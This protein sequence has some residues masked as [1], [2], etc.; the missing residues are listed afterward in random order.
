MPS[1][2]LR[3]LALDGG[4]VR[5]LSA[6]LILEHLMETVD[7]DAPP[8]PC[9]YFDMIGGTST[10][11]LIAVMLGRLKMSVPDC[12]AAYISLSDRIFRK[13]RHRMTMR[14]RVQGRFNAEELTRA[15]KEVV[16]QQGLQEDAL[17][18]DAPE[19]Q[20]K[21]FV[22]ATSKQAGGT[23]CLTSYRTPRGNNDLLNSATIW[24][25]CRATSA[26]PSF[27]DSITIGR[28][29]EEFIDGATGAN[30]P[31]RE[32]WDQAQ[33]VWGPAPLEG[34]VKCLVS[35]GTGVPSLKPFKNDVLHMGKALLAIATDTEESAERFRR[36]RSLLDSTQRY[37]RFN[38]L[39]GL[40]EIGLQETKKIDE[41]AAATRRYI[42]S[43]EVRMQ[44]QA[45]AGNIAGREYFGEYQTV[46]RLD[47]VPRTRQ[48]IDRQAEMAEIER[49]LMPGH[50]ERQKIHVLRGLGGIGKTQLAVEFAYRHH[51]RF[52]SVFWL[53]GRTKDTLLRSIVSCASRIPAGHITETSRTYT[54]DSDADVRIIVN[55]VLA[56]LA[57]ANNT[58][59]LLIF[60]NVDREYGVKDGDPHAYDVEHYLPGAPHGSVLIT[61]RL[62]RLERLGDSQQLGKVSKMQAQAIFESWYRKEHDKVKSERLLKL[63]DGLPLAIA[64]A[65]AYLHET[66]AELTTY[67]SFYEQQW[68]ALMQSDKDYSDGSVWTTWSISYQAIRK[69]HKDTANLLLLWSFLDNKDLWYGLF[70]TACRESP[71]TASM[72]SSWIGD[73][74]SSEFRFTEAM[75]LLRNYSLVEQVAETLSYATHPVVHQ[76]AYHSQGQNFATELSRLAVVTIGSTVPEKNCREDIIL[77]RRLLSHAQACSSRIAK[78]GKGFD[79]SVF[80][81]DDKDLE[82]LEEQKT[83]FCAVHMLGSLYAEQG[84]P[85]EAEQMYKCAF[86]GYQ[87]LALGPFHEA[88]LS[89]VHK[90]GLLYVEQGKLDEAEQMYERALQGFEALGPDHTMMLGVVNNS[91]GLLYAEQ[92]KVEKAEQMYKRALRGYEALEPNHT[93][94]L[95]IVSNLGHLYLGQGKLE[96]AEQMYE[97]ALRGKEEALG[98]TDTFTLDTV[99]G[100]GNLYIEQG[101]LCK[102]EEMLKRALQGYEENVG[103]I[104]P[105]T[106]GVVNS[107]GNFYMVKEELGKAEQMY[108]RALRGYEEAVGPEQVQQYRPALNALENLGNL[109]VARKESTKARTAYVR[110]LSGLSHILDWKSAVYMELVAKIVAL[111]PV[112]EAGSE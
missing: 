74:A 100:L 2:D 42:S 17:L 87:S 112:S 40:E 66:G 12:I 56:W 6:L 109:Y 51:K 81:R 50:N 61:T 73:I 45:C 67:L 8:K 29:G 10:G 103:P 32:V 43:Q 102:A 39:R 104:D 31:V 110:A 95:S 13:T 33:I 47:G 30:N 36:E 1:S 84:K 63:L 68:S 48:F 97:R 99:H 75:R 38:V 80:A 72:L 86:R 9:D 106:L 71:L 108:E 28:F 54:T 93:M 77:Q 49:H 94:T 98:P 21:V 90:L 69:K 15:V 101:D 53:D 20:C 62:A 3:L 37:Y 19:A 59:W 4:G 92:G 65:G 41:M 89:T 60:D 82:E 5:G 70:A 96:Q 44:M 85:I 57:R 22:C 91:L 55:D 79:Y 7:P 78:K 11:G 24:E 58:A 105:A 25:A 16:K 52:S 64:Q 34:R 111:P 46:F 107:L 76:W 18:K 26:A 27:F 14:G 88:T 23:V 35:I 83:I